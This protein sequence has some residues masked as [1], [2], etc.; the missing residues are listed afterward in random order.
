LNGFVG[1]WLLYL[2]LMKVGLAEESRHGVAALLT[3]GLFALTGGLAAFAFVRLTGIALLGSPRSDV[4]RHAHESSPWMLGPMTVLAV[5]CLVMAMVPNFA[6]D[7][8]TPVVDQMLH[9]DRDGLGGRVRRGEP[10]LT[11]RYPRMPGA[12]DRAGG[13][14]LAVLLPHREASVRLDLGLRL[15]ATD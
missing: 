6:V 12:C 4:A 13:A 10:S 7:R 11:V 9:Q 14:L 2:G 15:R 1:E 8:L 5:L 3:V